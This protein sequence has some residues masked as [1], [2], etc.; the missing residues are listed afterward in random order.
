MRV[1]LTVDDGREDQRGAAE[2]RRWLDGVP[3]LRGRVE[4]GEQDAVP[5]GA[6][7]AG[8]DAL[9]AVLE[10]GGVAAVFVGAVAAWVRTRRG[11][12]TVTVT[13]PDGTEI[14][15]T[16]Q[17]SMTPEEA[18]AA[19]ERLAPSEEPR[20]EAPGPEEQAPGGQAG[21]RARP[22]GERPRPEEQRRTD[23]GS[24]GASS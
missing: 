13:R 5:A 23:E 6:M 2:L 10:P 15:I 17:D 8:A 22:G 21:D 9:V 24:S 11:S 14:T 12:Y 18:V 16:S 3:Q 20:P 7:G 1:V 4:R 19:A